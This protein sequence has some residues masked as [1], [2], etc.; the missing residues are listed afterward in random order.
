M[1]M[2]IAKVR[3]VVRVSPISVHARDWLDNNW[4]TSHERNNV[5]EVQPQLAISMMVAALS[6]GVALA[7]IENGNS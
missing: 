2:R 3:D 6:A 4:Y 1:D 5:L 7:F